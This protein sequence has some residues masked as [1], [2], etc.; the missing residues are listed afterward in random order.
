MAD[1]NIEIL[2]KETYLKALENSVGSRLFNSL[3]VRYKHTG[4]IKDI[5]NNCELSC[6]FFTSNI[7]LMF[8]VLEKPFA[9]VRGLKASID[10]NGKWKKISLGEVE[11]G[12]VV[13]WE[14][15]KHEDGTETAHVGFMINKEEAVSTSTKSK[16]VARHSA[17][18]RA[19][20]SIYRYS[21]E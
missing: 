4:E 2:K 7:L 16:M 15:K 6:A 19:I 21:W 13:F 20:D 8:G 17:M 11:K 10:Q 1:A 3:F 18:N 9:T 5:L 12:D 14:K